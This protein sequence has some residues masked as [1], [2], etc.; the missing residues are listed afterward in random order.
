M[1][2]VDLHPVATVG[3]GQ[4]HLVVLVVGDPPVRRSGEAVGKPLRLAGE[5][6]LV[7]AIAVHRKG[8]E[9]PSM[10]PP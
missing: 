5:V 6:G 2:G 8:F 3:V 4:P 9:M 7:M 10:E 1:T